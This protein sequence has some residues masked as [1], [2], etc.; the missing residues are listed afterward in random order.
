MAFPNYIKGWRS[1]FFPNDGDGWEDRGEVDK[2]AVLKEGVNQWSQKACFRC[3]ANAH[4]GRTDA[5]EVFLFCPRCLVVLTGEKKRMNE[6]DVPL[7]VNR[8]KKPSSKR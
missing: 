2:H 1:I 7:R 4:V 8:S 5:G 3:D 6:S